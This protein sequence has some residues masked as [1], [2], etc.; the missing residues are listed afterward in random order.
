V[1]I[2]ELTGLALGK[3]RT[4]RGKRKAG[5]A[6]AYDTHMKAVHACMSRED[7]S[8]AKAALLR[9]ANSLP[10]GDTEHTEERPA[11][12]VSQKLAGIPAKSTASPAKGLSPALRAY[13]LSKNKG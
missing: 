6:G 9:A 8:G 7:F 1:N 2:T 11:A 13:L 12:D 4:R 5:T 3:K 10:T